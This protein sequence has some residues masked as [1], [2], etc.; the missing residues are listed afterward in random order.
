MTTEKELY[1]KLVCFEHAMAEL[2]LEYIDICN[3]AEEAG[4]LETDTADQMLQTVIELLQ[5]E[6][7]LRQFNF[8]HAVKEA[9]KC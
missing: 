6:S 8:N 9:E 7:K 2:S 1:A 3:A 5:V 4:L